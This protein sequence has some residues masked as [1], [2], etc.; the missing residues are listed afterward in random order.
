MVNIVGRKGRGFEPSLVTCL[1]WLAAFN[2]SR[3]NLV[4]VAPCIIQ[5]QAAMCC[6]VKGFQKAYQPVVISDL[7]PHTM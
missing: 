3:Q 7:H 5:S 4:D 2:R 6:A 1:T